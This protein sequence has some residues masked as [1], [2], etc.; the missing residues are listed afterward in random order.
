MLLEFF[1]LQGKAEQIRNFQWT[2]QFPTLSY[3][4]V[5]IFA[6]LLP[7]RMIYEFQKIGLEIV[8]S[9]I[10]SK[11]YPN[12]GY[13]HIIELIDQY[14]VWF[15]IPFSVIILGYSIRWSTLE[16]SPMCLSSR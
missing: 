7:F 9:I 13:H 15:T 2:S 14:F 4:F 11:P 10:Q 6:I 12:G 3:V 16:K 1:P 8:E 5:A